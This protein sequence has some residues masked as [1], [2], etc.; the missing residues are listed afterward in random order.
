MSSGKATLFE[1]CLTNLSTRHHWNGSGS[2]T[3][4]A[5]RCSIRPVADVIT[6]TLLLLLLAWALYIVHRHHQ[7]LTHVW[8][9]VLLVDLPLTARSKWWLL[10][11]AFSDSST[12]PDEKP[13]SST[14]F[15]IAPTYDESVET[16]LIVAILPPIAKMV[17]GF[18][19][20]TNRVVNMYT[21]DLC[22][23]LAFCRIRLCADSV[24]MD[25]HGNIEVHIRCAIDSEPLR[26]ALTSRDGRDGNRCFWDLP[27]VH[28]SPQ[29]GRNWQFLAHEWPF[30]SWVNQKTVTISYWN[31]FC[32]FSG[33]TATLV[34][35]AQHLHV[36][37]LDRVALQC[38][39]N[40][41]FV[42]TYYFLHT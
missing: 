12:L 19:G 41:S 25:G 26:V 8:R 42:C 3:H 22:S 9:N 7:R 27:Y 2:S 37:A 11:R 14:S 23:Y 32:H 15:R 36:F 6:L 28:E 4:N 5:N 13:H 39:S 17:F 10:I 21:D 16:I 40:G 34:S 35:D 31:M 18:L 33:C 20:P 30:L 1:P 24:S 29:L 38:H